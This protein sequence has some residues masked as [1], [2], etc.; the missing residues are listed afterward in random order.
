MAKTIRAMVTVI[1]KTKE[2]T[3]RKTTATLGRDPGGTM[4]YC[5][6]FTRSILV[7]KYL[8]NALVEAVGTEDRRSTKL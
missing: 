1:M 2:T 8:I 7:L 3:E 4:T 5:M 6:G